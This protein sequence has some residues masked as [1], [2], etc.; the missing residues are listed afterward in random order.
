MNE[1]EYVDH[2]AF[3]T[4]AEFAATVAVALVCVVSVAVHVAPKAWAQIERMG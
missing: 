1:K 2:P 3:I 4:R